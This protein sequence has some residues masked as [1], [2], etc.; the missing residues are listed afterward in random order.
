M[1]KKHCDDVIFRDTLNVLKTLE[2]THENK[3]IS[4]GEPIY[5]I[6]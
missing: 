3:D 5:K 4:L 6:W 2:N 1:E